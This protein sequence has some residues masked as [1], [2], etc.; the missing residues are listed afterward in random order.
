[1]THLFP[2]PE[3]CWP[4]DRRRPGHAGHPPPGPAGPGR[5]RRPRGRWRSTRAPTRR[6]WATGCGAIRGI[7]PWTAGYVAMRALGDPDAFLPTDLGVRPGPGRLGAPGRPPRRWPSAGGPGA[8]T[9]PSTCGTTCPPQRPKGG[10]R[11]HARRLGR[12]EPPRAAWPSTV[13]SARSPICTSPTPAPPPRRL[14]TR[15]GARAPRAG[16]PQLDEYFAR[17]RTAFD[18]PLRPAGT[19]FQ[20]AVW[21]ALADIGYGRDRHLRRAGD[22]GSGGPGPSGRWAR[23]TGPT[24]WPSSCPATGSWPRAAAWAATGAAWTPSAALLALERR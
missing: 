24:R 15:A 11:M 9:P 21:W 8:P 20:L 5:R 13:T 3:A 19:P 22:G 4:T 6:R 10:C 18:L 16:R 17:R 7:G 1:M 14:V 12:R 2:G 23:P